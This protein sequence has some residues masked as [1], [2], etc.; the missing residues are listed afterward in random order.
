MKNII[1]SIAAAL[2]MIVSLSSFAKGSFNPLKDKSSADVMI[3]YAEAVTAGNYMFNKYLFTD[4]FEY[5]N[6]AN[7]LV[8]NKRNYIKL[9]ESNKGLKYNCTTNY[10]ILDQTGKSCIA[11]VTMDFN[12]FQRVDLVTLKL[13]DNGW[14][15]SK[16]VTTYP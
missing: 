1:K 16:V 13:T 3:A 5:E 8:L 7:K 11:K 10:Q 6:V 4:D 2:L 15:I 9:I 14:K 12:H